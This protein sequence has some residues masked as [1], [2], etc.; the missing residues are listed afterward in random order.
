MLLQKTI[1]I[2]LHGRDLNTVSGKLV[3][4]ILVEL[5]THLAGL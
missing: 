1:T 2:V 5:G 3:D 4:T